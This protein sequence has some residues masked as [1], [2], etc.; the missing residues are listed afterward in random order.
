MGKFANQKNGILLKAL[1]WK[2]F[3]I[4]Y[5]HLVFLKP[6]GVFYGHLVNFVVVWYILFHFGMEFE[7]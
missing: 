2:T 5:G 6:F 4:C 7:E 3:V 1:E